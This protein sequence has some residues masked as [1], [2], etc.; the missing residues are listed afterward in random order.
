MSLD[1]G[2]GLI[3]FV[4][5]Y[6]P[7]FGAGGA[8]F[9]ASLHAGLLVAAGH[10]VVVITPNFG[11]AERETVDGVEIHR[12][13]FVGLSR[14]GAQAG[15]R[16]FASPLYRA[17]LARAIAAAVA[18]RKVHCI[19]AQHQFVATAAAAAARSLGAPFVA[20]LRDTSQICGVGALCLLEAG[21]DVPPPQCGLV[22]NMWCHQ[23]RFVKTYVPNAS[24]L[25]R[26]ARL[27]SG[28]IDYRIWRSRARA[29]DR[30][31]RIAFA[32]DG[33]RRLYETLPAFA[34]GGRHRVV[35]APILPVAGGEVRPDLLPEP[36]R[37]L[38][39][40]G[41]QIVLFVGKVSIGKGCDVM[42]EAWRRLADEFPDARLVVAGN[43]QAD[44]W[45]ID[46]T[47][48]ELLGFVA[49]EAVPALYAA[50][51]IVLLPSTWP[52]PLGWATLDSARHAKPIVATR[53]GGV[54]E[55]VVDGETGYLVNRLDPAAMAEG[56]RRLLRDPAA[57]RAMGASARER[58]DRRFGPAAVL[59][60]LESL[61]G[62][63]GHA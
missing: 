22:Q 46:R 36:L 25:G 20:H 28:F 24:L 41:R 29:Y 52:E 34:D 1:T 48:T 54:P 45:S 30:A 2:E 12:H 57:G 16:Q 9:T 39:A 13:R 53:V 37:R 42:F 49:R 21:N 10:R 11:A 51:D 38:K 44:A 47:R 15:A 32:S 55:A 43:I 6:Y 27:G 59:G 17:R 61:Y 4:T 19:H 31:S 3:V 14:A 56:L 50:A 5:P 35:Y 8:E 63:I 7:P 62:G 18:G 58:L 60:Q 33:L 23:N 40:E 26:V